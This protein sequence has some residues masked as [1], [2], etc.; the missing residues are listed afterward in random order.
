MER[1]NE[2]NKIIKDKIDNE[3]KERILSCAED[4]ENI[5][6]AYDGIVDEECFY[7]KG[8]KKIL[9][10]LKDPNGKNDYADGNGHI[11]EDLYNTAI[12]TEETENERTKLILTYRN[13]CMFTKIIEDPNFEL[14]DCWTSKKGF[15]VDEMRGFLKHI[16]VVNIRKS[17]G[18]GNCS[19]KKIKT[20]VEEYYALI[21]E[22]IDIIKPSIVVCGGIF[23]FIKNNY[24]S[25]IKHL[26]NGA[27]YFIYNN[28][29]YLEYYHPGARFGYE[30]HFNVFKRTYD[31]LCHELK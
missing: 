28:C 20:A 14:E 4:G 27:R 31:E 22:E 29:I 19:N 23:D 6:L 21:K 1:K 15:A 11:D 10:L 3:Y 12:A 25:E 30:K 7:C 2:I 24:Q 5:S 18:S 26:V 17:V 8:S 13:V 16:A 9:F